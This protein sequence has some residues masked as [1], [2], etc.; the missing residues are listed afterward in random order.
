MAKC[1]FEISFGP[2]VWSFHQANEQFV[3]SRYFLHCQFSCVPHPK[4]KDQYASARRKQPTGK[5][6]LPRMDSLLW[7]VCGTAQLV[8][9]SLDGWVVAKWL[10]YRHTSG[11]RKVQ[12]VQMER[13]NF[14]GGF[15]YICICDSICFK[16]SIHIYR[17]INQNMKNRYLDKCFW[18]LTWQF[19]PTK[20]EQHFPCGYC[21]C[22]W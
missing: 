11:W 15:H 6:F 9:I 19:P 22:S 5:S 21:D 10:V 8:S 17:F 12:T 16:F 4:R 7:L 2:P 1:V 13:S 18:A 14:L 20:T 3:H